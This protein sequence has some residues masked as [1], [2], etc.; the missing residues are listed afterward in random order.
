MNVQS[1]VR[2]GEPPF[3]R[4]R[5]R[6]SFVGATLVLGG[7]AVGWVAL[8]TPFVSLI[9][10]GAR[11]ATQ[12]LLGLVAWSAALAA[13]LAFIAAGTARMAA[14]IRSVRSQPRLVGTPL[15]R[16]HD[17]DPAAWTVV[18]GVRLPDGHVIEALAVGPFGVALVDEV[19]PIAGEGRGAPAW[20]MSG[21][22]ESPLDR[23]ARSAQAIRRWCTDADLGFAVR[24]HA[25][26]VSED[27]AL[28]RTPACAVIRE[29]QILPWLASLPLQRSLTPDRQALIAGLLQD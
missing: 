28:V 4:R 5:V 12:P 14:V 19:A 20:L 27:P 6:G 24:V 15:S 10:P 2:A 1:R 21:R 8:A 17:R 18:S 3:E 29:A 22:G 26:V 23:T 9:T 7:I 13:P 11:G 16:A 25:A